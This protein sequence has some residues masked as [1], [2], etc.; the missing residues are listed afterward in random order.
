LEEQRAKEA[1]LKAIEEAKRAAEEKERIKREKAELREKLRAEGKLLTP[2]ER[3]RREERRAQ[4]E[5]MVQAGMVDRSVLEKFDEAQDLDKLL[6]KEQQPQQPKKKIVYEDKRKHKQQQQQRDQSVNH[7]ADSSAVA[8]PVAPAPAV[9]SPPT[10]P[11]NS[12]SVEAAAPQQRKTDLRSPICCVMGHVDTGKTKLL[13]KLRRSNVQGG[14]AGGITQQIGATYFPLETIREQTQKLKE[15]V[16]VYYGYY[17]LTVQADKILY[18]IP[19][20]LVMDTPGHES[21]TN[22]RSR[23]ASLCDIAVLVVDIMHG[24]EP[25]TKESIDLLRARGTPF[26]VA[27]NKI[28]RLYEWK[29]SPNRPVQIALK[30][31]APHVQLEFNQRVQ[32]TIVA[33]QELGLN[34]EVFTAIL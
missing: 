1:E 18:N 13:D 8:T 30:A 11:V 3:K 26:V 17:I 25:Q 20:L 21:F 7:S 5:R 2:A 12:T 4:L 24:I 27:L 32:E 29:S 9:V 34:A 31:Q 14:E 19:G 16:C 22:L 33:F 6:E 10:E 23:G 28:D 15:L